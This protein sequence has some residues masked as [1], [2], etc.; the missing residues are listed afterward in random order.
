MAYQSGLARC[1]GRFRSQRPFLRDSLLEDM[2]SCRLAAQNQ[3][4]MQFV[5]MIFYLILLST[6]SQ[7]TNTRRLT[8]KLRVLFMPSAL[9]NSKDTP[10]RLRRKSWNEGLPCSR[11]PSGH[12]NLT[13][14]APNEV[15]FVLS[16]MLVSENPYMSTF[17]CKFCVSSWVA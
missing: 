6:D 10:V 16:P 12:P 8:L 1:L 3:N 17:L 2:I 15:D 9:S 11:A 5:H 4:S 13:R 7:I 14:I